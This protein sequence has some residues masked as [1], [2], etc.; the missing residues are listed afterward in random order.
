MTP[1]L[2]KA[3][4]R[5]HRCA[6]QLAEQ[7]EQ[8]EAIY[9]MGLAAE[10]AIKFHLQTTGFRPRKPRKNQ[11]PAKDPFYLHF[12]EL[13]TELLAQAS[14][15]VSSRVLAKLKDG[16]LCNGWH[17]KMRY[18]DQPSTPSTIRKF[19]TWRDQTAELFQEIGL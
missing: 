3:A 18:A 12:P 1:N 11:E 5:H 2:A 14:G 16:S 17:V 15:I 9:L 6:V 8:G 7:K 19:Q 10:C 13:T 4:N